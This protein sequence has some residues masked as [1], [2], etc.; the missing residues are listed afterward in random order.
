M[1]SAVSVGPAA[2]RL[3]CDVV[4]PAGGAAHTRT[5]IWMHGLG[6]SSDGF[7]DVFESMLELPGTR[8]VLP[9]APVR[10]ITCNGGMKMRGW[11][12]IKSISERAADM[13]DLDGIRSSAAALSELIAE[14]TALVGSAAAITIGG[15]SQGAAMAVYTGLG[16]ADQLGSIVAFSG[17]LVDRASYPGRVSVA[18]AATPLFISN[19][20]ADAIVAY[21]WAR[22][23]WQDLKRAALKIFYTTEG[24]QGHELTA[25]QLADL[26]S[27]ILADRTARLAL[28]AENGASKL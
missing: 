19:G 6:D 10:R 20:Q 8:V 13:E 28:C 12:D 23:G 24:R 14:E 2:A 1:A 22:E 11:Y 26:Q 25:R 3:E 4:P 27:W 9:N 15:F 5:V 16:C 7:K 17:Y 18:N 21:E